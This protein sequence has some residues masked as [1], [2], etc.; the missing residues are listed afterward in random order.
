[1]GVDP[2]QMKL[3]NISINKLSFIIANITEDTN[4]Y[5]FAIKRY[6]NYIHRSQV[7]WFVGESQSDDYR[8]SNNYST[9]TVSINSNLFIIVISSITLATLGILYRR[10]K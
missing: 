2:D 5:I 10:Y 8:V 3:Y 7:T 9:N 6:Y 1:M 4:F